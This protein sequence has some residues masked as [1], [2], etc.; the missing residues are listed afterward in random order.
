MCCLAALLFARTTVRSWN[1]RSLLS[2]RPDLKTR[3]SLLILVNRLILELPNSLAP[4][5]QDGY[6][7]NILE[8]RP[9]WSR[10]I[11]ALYQANLNCVSALAL[12]RD[13]LA[14]ERTIGA[15]S[16]E[17]ELPLKNWIES[18]AAIRCSEDTLLQEAFTIDL[19]G[20]A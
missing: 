19:G 14:N 11:N 9:N 8:R 3:P 7:G 20:E 2:K 18:F 15:I 4:S 6:L 16:E 12:I 17:T 10:Q 13:S 5:S 1:I